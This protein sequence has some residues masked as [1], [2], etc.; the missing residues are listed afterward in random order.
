MKRFSC[1]DVVPNCKARFEAAGE[2]DLLAQ[3][4]RH[5]RNDHGLLSMPDDLLQEV[6]RHIVDFDG[7]RG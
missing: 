1:G 5:A 2:S 7:A 6:K 3:I 4:A